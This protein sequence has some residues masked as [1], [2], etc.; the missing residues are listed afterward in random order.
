[1][2]QTTTA[3]DPPRTSAA[4]DLGALLSPR[5][6]AVLGALREGGSARGI[7]RNL[8]NAGYTGDVHPISAKLDEVLGL[9]CHATLA[10]VPQAPESVVVAI[11]AAHVPATLREARGLGVKA[12]VIVSSGFG[13]SGEEGRERQRELRE[14]VDDGMAICGPNCF[15]TI[16]VARATPCYL[17]ALPSALVPGAVGLVSQS[18][19]MTD[20]VLTALMDD[21][22]VGFSYVVSCGNQVGVGLEDCLA[23]L[24]EDPATR[25][26]ACLAEGITAPTRLRE[27]ARRAAALGKAIVMLKSGRSETGQRSTL[28]H[29]GSLAGS[30]EVFDALCR[31][32]GIVNCRGLD[33]LIETVCLLSYELPPTPSRAL[34]V[35]TGSGGEA[36]QIADA[37]EPLG[38]AFPSLTEATGTRLAEVMPQFGNVANPVDGTGAMFSRDIFQGILDAVLDDDA[39][40]TLLVNLNPRFAADRPRYAAPLADTLVAA[41]DRD[42]K[43]LIAYG[44]SALGPVDREMLAQLAEAGIP[45]LLGTQGALRALRNRTTLLERR[46]APVAASAAAP[47]A[48]RP[49][50]LE[51]GRHVD[52]ALACDLLE[53][54]GIPVQRGCLVDDAAAAVAAARAAGGP[55]AMKL[56]HERFLHKSDVGGVK[57]GCEGDDAVAAAFEA[58]IA[59]PRAQLGDDAGARVLVQPMAPS[60]L[61][62]IVG[63][64]VDP[65]YGPVVVLGLGGVYVELLRDVALLVPPVD[66]DEVRRAIA[67]LRGAALLDGLRGEAPRD[68]D[69]LVEVLLRAC[70]MCAEQSDV[71]ESFDLNPTIAYGRGEGVLAV[72]VRVVVHDQQEEPSA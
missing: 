16:D 7:V 63:G 17:G 4:P 56:E 15:G 42:R 19:G 29:T 67:S 25:V 69:A 68:L 10:D 49:S 70:R 45:F 5:S 23:H 41:P 66:A 61:E 34:A 54:Y 1:M 26:V 71:V 2:S 59:I 53:A 18:G 9:P 65:L 27:S 50:G 72:D 55:V 30:P 8:V 39:T 51:R 40:D 21:R 36:A 37:G 47:P 32:E 24:L 6:I 52:H 57:L 48:P 64:R 31:Q 35:I 11:P 44:S 28:S 58:L 33:E 38:F 46:A 43:P 20:A 13:E 62:L 3:G 22:H 60:G 12:A 14:L